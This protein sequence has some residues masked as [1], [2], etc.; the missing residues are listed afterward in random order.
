MH[1]ASMTVQIF[2]FI[3]L[4]YENLEFGRVMAATLETSRFEVRRKPIGSIIRSIHEREKAKPRIR[5]RNASKLAQLEPKIGSCR[6][7]KS[8]KTLLLRTQAIL[9]PHQPTKVMRTTFIME[10]SLI[11]PISVILCPRQVHQSQ[12]N[13]GLK[14]HANLDKVAGKI[15][16]GNTR[17]FR[18][19]TQIITFRGGNLGQDH[20]AAALVPLAQY[21]AKRSHHSVDD[22]SKFECASS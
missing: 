20:V 5:A 17:K 3:H 9:M 4:W 15:V 10:P 6:T 18:G 22:V 2:Q 1:Q 8:T 14:D 13:H 16:C 12:H 19:I 21:M 11:E 7:S